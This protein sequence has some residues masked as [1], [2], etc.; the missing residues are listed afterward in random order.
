MGQLGGETMC[1]RAVQRVRTGLEA[2]WVMVPH[3]ANR[4]SPR[5]LADQC[6]SDRSVTRNKGEESWGAS[7][8]R[9]TFRGHPF[10]ESDRRAPRHEALQLNSHH[11]FYL[12]PTHPLSVDRPGTG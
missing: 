3:R 4:S 2:V 7:L 9:V 10:P 11:W 6:D 12:S 1:H 5:Q 8:S